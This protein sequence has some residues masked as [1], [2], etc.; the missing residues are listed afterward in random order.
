MIF[1]PY[2]HFKQFFEGRYCS[3]QALQVT[4]DCEYSTH[5]ILTVFLSNAVYGLTID[6]S[7]MIDSLIS[8]I[9]SLPFQSSI[10]APSI[11]ANI[12]RLVVAFCFP[13]V[14]KLFMT[15]WRSTA[16]FASLIATLY[17]FSFYDT[18]RQFGL[19]WCSYTAVI[20]IYDTFF[21]HAYLFST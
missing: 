3:L 18:Q 13:T 20:W 4:Q 10:S 15:F 21:L 14:R 5:A 12:C 9:L 16:A 8:C 11:L 6:A 19:Y 2:L 1:S 7:T 17:D